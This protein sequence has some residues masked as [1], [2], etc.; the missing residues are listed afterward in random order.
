MA[1]G[2]PK[3]NKKRRHSQVDND[4]ELAAKVPKVAQSKP[5][6]K[7]TLI[8]DQSPPLSEPDGAPATR[9]KRK[10]KFPKRPINKSWMTHISAVV[11]C[12]LVDDAV[13]K[14]FDPRQDPNTTITDGFSLSCEDLKKLW[15]YIGREYPSSRT[16][17][18]ILSELT[19]LHKVTPIDI[20]NQETIMK[21]KDKV[22][23]PPATAYFQFVMSK[24]SKMREKHPELGQIDVTRRLAQK[25][26]EIGPERRGKY[27]QRYEH[28]KKQY[29]TEI[30]EF[31][32]EHPDARPQIKERQKTSKAKREKKEDVTFDSEAEKRYKELKLL[33]PKPPVTAYF[34]F[35]SAK[36]GRYK[37]KHP[38]LKPSEITRKL[39]DK[40]HSLSTERQNKYK[41]VYDDNY[42]EYK[43]K[44]EE[45]Y[46]RYPD[47][48]ELFKRSKGSR[49][50]G[51]TAAA[52]ATLPTSTLSV[53]PSPPAQSNS[54]SGLTTTSNKNSLQKHEVKKEEEDKESDE[55]E[56]SS[57]D[58]EDGSD[59]DSDSDSHSDDNDHQKKPAA[60][61]KTTVPTSKTTT[62]TAV[63]INH[64]VARKEI[65]LKEESSDSSSSGSD[66][67]DSSSSSDDD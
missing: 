23:K 52:T 54:S 12:K 5:R 41:K 62:T 61:T 6:A 42:K 35:V 60:V 46:D 67:D 50:K 56:S 47:A 40:W 43:S 63:R 65:K 15:Y 58:E 24:Q 49:A 59:E 33:A 20:I 21:Y 55:E 32:S 2:G 36:R 4:E 3:K 27:I 16:L 25:W 26:K 29:K 8:E 14:K 13:K 39:A 22:P 37:D 1:E 57:S 17:N 19:P 44:L 34:L 66:N 38:N 28:L 31:Y 7:P 9:A 18:D 45:F 11:I 30:E 10:F 48:K 51:K 53:T 64:P